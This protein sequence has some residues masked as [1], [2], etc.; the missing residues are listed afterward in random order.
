MVA[1]GRA[2]GAFI[3]VDTPFEAA[4]V[5]LLVEGAGGKVTSLE[6]QASGAFR[7]DTKINGL[8]VTNG[9]IHDNLL[10]VLKI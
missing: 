8:V 1:S 7:Y 4:A 3:G 6:G 10:Q 5:K 9:L 2:E